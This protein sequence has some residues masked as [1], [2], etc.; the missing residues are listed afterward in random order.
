MRFWR[1]PYTCRR[2]GAG[3]SPG[4]GV[5][6]ESQV[7]Y[8]RFVLPLTLGALLPVAPATAD[9][10]GQECRASE[11]GWDCRGAGYG[12]VEAPF[13]AEA[14]AAAAGVKPAA[15][16][17]Q[18]P[19]AP[20]ALRPGGKRKA[21]ARTARRPAGRPVEAAPA[22]Q[23][24]FPLSLDEGLG[25]GWCG[26]PDTGLPASAAAPAAPDA[27]VEAEAD[28][29]QVTIGDK[30]V[31]LS[32]DVRLSHGADTVQADSIR[33]DRQ[34]NRVD[35][36]GNVFLTRPDLRVKGDAGWFELDA[37]RGELTGAEY[38]LVGFNARGTAEKIRVEGEALSEHHDVTYTTC[39]PGS[40]AWL[41]SAG[42]LQF[43]RAEGFGDAR[44]AVLRIAD[45]PVAYVPRFVFPIDERR[46]SGFLYPTVGGGG[47]S[48]FKLAVPYYLNLAPNYDAT[49]VPSVLGK[50]GFL[51]GA[52]ARHLSESS[53]SDLRG[54]ILPHDNEE[55]D[56]GVRGFVSA[57]HHQQWDRLRTDL[58]Y[59]YVSDDFFLS[60]V[61]T[62]LAETSTRYLNR[63]ALASYTGDG[64]YGVAGV[65]D[66]Q[67]VQTGIRPYRLLPTITLGGAVPQQVGGQTLSLGGVA[68]YSNFDRDS[69]VVG[70]RVD[71]YPYVTLPMRS[72]WGYVLPK[73]G[74][75]YTSYSLSDVL[76][77]Q[78]DSIDRSLGVG[79]VDSGLYFERD[80]AWFG[81]AVTQ[82]LEPRLYYLY[83]P[84]VD[85]NEIPIFD[86]TQYQQLYESLFLENQF[87]GADRVND[88][89]RLSAGV[90]TRFLAGDSGVEMLRLSVGQ[91]YYFADRRVQLP[92]QPTQTSSTSPV[93]GEVGVQL[94][95]NWSVLA[96]GQWDSSKSNT[97]VYAPD[98]KA[99]RVAYRGDD[100]RFVRAR[101]GE[102]QTVTEFYDVAFSWPVLQNVNAIGR[103]AYSLQDDNVMEAL[104]GVEYGSCCW[105]LRAFVRQGLRPTSSSSGD[106]TVGQE[107]TSFLVQ[108][109]L[110]GLGPLG[111]DADEFLDRSLHGFVKSDHLTY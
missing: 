14:P 32:G 72:A 111:S 41:L 102:T 86:T 66:Y 76:E 34:A 59:N 15:R 20:K 7:S 96:S 27:L 60:D 45:V 82:T 38:R 101:Y 26:F 68:N 57:E 39:R 110:R 24:S 30:V 58:V 54:V 10:D 49:L 51:L 17:A 85:Q 46:R 16:G 40:S 88:M 105:R 87:T 91:A 77:A 103:L 48:G 31:L 94:D 62:T 1:A 43:D 23:P 8:A 50:R 104:A 79:S 98:Q 13:A 19:V 33:F 6:G 21:A 37:Q 55:P 3:P 92:G 83:I 44:D 74:F 53:W 18:A 67:Q 65:V 95:R 73:A 108:L 22:P 25:W 29:A 9:V 2:T 64:W 97:S 35:A 107:D 81:K 93:Y 42:S 106:R 109:E 4:T 5:D 70:Q 90:S 100:G 69:G 52:E 12:V 11:A 47:S 28:S 89:N 75:R 61:G 71:L 56:L 80:T 63:Q 36:Q 84:Y 99:F 78:P